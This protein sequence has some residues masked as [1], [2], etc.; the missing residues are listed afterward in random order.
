MVA[1]SSLYDDDDDD[2]ESL[3][4]PSG[5]N[6]ISNAIMHNDIIAIILFTILVTTAVLSLLLLQLDYYYYY[7]YY[8]YR[9]ST[10]TITITTT[11][12][13]SN[14]YECYNDLYSLILSLN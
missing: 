6:M 3:A 12:T 10:I 13:T 2:L 8:L 1:S 14:L 11:T 5:S 7:Y 9:V 4:C